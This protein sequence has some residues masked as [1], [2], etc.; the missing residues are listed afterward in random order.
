[1][2]STELREDLIIRYRFLHDHQQKFYACL[3]DIITTGLWQYPVGLE[4]Q[5]AWY[6]LPEADLQILEDHAIEL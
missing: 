2:L 3:K 4:L 5:A 1:M 6:A